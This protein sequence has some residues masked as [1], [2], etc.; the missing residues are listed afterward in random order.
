MIQE[1]GDHLLSLQLQSFGNIPKSY[2]K[3]EEE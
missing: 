2:K 3:K 1:L